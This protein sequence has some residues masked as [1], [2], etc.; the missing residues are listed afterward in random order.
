MIFTSNFKIA[1]HLSQAIAISQ[2][3]PRGWQGRTYKPLAPAW[4]LVKLTDNEQ[5]IKLYRAQ[6][7]DRLDAAQVLQ[8]LGGDDFIMLCWEAP[9]VFCHRRVVAAWLQKELGITVEELVPTY[10][11]HQEW[12]RRMERGGNSGVRRFHKR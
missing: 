2:G 10:R 6:V 9:G 11:Q 1:G 4:T 8:D 3:I 5:F 12:L 7:L